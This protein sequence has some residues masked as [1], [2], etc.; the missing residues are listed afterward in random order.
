MKWH[1]IRQD[2]AD[3]LTVERGIAKD[4]INVDLTIDGELRRR[5]GYLKHTPSVFTRVGGPDVAVW[6]PEGPDRGVVVWHGG[7]AVSD[8]TPPNPLWWRVDIP[9]DVPEQE[10]PP[11]DPQREELPPEMRDPFRWIQIEPLRPI[12][13]EYVC[14]VT[15]PSTVVPG[16]KTATIE[17]TEDGSAA[18]SAIGGTVV[19]AYDIDG[20][21][22][23]VTQATIAKLGAAS[24]GYEWDLPNAAL[25]GNEGKSITVFAYAYDIRRRLR[26]SETAQDTSTVGAYS[27]F[28]VLDPSEAQP[29][30]D[31]SGEGNDWDSGTGSY[32]VVSGGYWKDGGGGGDTVSTGG[33]YTPLD[34]SVNGNFTFTLDINIVSLSGNPTDFDI[35]GGWLTLRKAENS[36]TTKILVNGGLVHT[37]NTSGTWTFKVVASSSGGSTTLTFYE[38]TT[39]LTS[40]TVATPA[41][42]TNMFDDIGV[43]DDVGTD[44]RVRNAEAF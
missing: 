17:F 21:L 25:A 27:G 16:D 37:W 1:G 41:T 19:L 40:T 15:L 6:V 14:T 39:L 30:T 43:I 28:T 22:Q 11:Q 9:P 35:I 20:A 33:A 3:V 5:P 12:P 38:G 29:Y 18:F 2:V 24:V 13:G 7:G 42:G 10:D 31:S 26:C 32:F 34:L 4:A 8:Y 36:Q 44:I 23:D